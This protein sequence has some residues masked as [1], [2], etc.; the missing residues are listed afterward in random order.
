[1]PLGTVGSGTR[2]TDEVMEVEPLWAASVWSTYMGRIYG[3]YCR[4]IIGTYDIIYP[5]MI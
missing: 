1:M 5:Y 4:H 3:G 2:A